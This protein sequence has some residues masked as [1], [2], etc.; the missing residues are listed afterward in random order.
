MVSLHPFVACFLSLLVCLHTMFVF[1]PLLLFPAI[2][3]SWSVLLVST[4]EL[5]ANP[6]ISALL[7]LDHG[8]PHSLRPAP[9]AA[10]GLLSE[11]PELANLQLL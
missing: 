11:R 10:T 9:I 6:S 4:N 8:T 2:R 7:E 1:S 5:S 3:G